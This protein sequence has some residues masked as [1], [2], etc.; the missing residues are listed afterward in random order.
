MILDNMD[1]EGFILE[2]ESRPILYDTTHPLYKD[3][4][5]KDLGRI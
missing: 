1:D 3:N 5:R 2:V 4:S